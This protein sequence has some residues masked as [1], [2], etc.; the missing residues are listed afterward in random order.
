MPNPTVRQRLAMA[1][2]I[3]TGGAFKAAARRDK[4][5]LIWPDYQSGQPQWQITDFQSYIDAGFN[6]NSL[7]YSAVMYKVRAKWTAPLRAYTGTRDQPEPLDTS[8]PLAQLVARPNPN[9]SQGEFEGGLTAFFN[10]AGN[11][12]AWLVRM[13]TDE[14]PIAMYAPRP[15]RVFIVPHPDKKLILGYIY[16][17]EGGAQADGIPILPQD[18]MH[19]K[20]PNPGDPLDGLGY[21]LSSLSAI[22]RSANVDND[23][24][25][26]LK[27]FFN[28]GAMLPGLLKFFSQPAITP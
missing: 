8:H 18:M 21:G 7:I 14:L 16:I 15:D 27:D 23:I 1:R 5:P 12:Y 9:Q 26:F 20:L 6:I 28:K 25:A 3:I 19:I 11:A 17:P 13:R 4:F 10:L 22:A 2:D 24:T